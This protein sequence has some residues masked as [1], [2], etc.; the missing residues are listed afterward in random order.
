MASGA[1]IS[2]SGAVMLLFLAMGGSGG[3][4]RSVSLASALSDLLGGSGRALIDL[5]VINAPKIKCYRFRKVVS[6]NF[7][8]K[9][10]LFSKC[11]K[12]LQSAEFQ[13]VSMIKF[14]W[15]LY[16]FRQ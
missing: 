2:V 7:Y 14:V 8:P 5:D 3:V 6:I 15:F 10:L 13:A 9:V 11:G 16:E 12:I 4:D 1:D